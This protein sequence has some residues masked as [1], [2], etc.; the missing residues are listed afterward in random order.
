MEE[1]V[2]VIPLGHE[3]DRAVKPFEKYK[4]NRVHI[5]SV[6][7][8]F[9]KYSL[10]MVEEQK[11]FTNTVADRLR[12]LGIGITIH[13]LDMFNVLEVIKKISNIIYKEKTDGNIVYVNISSAGRLTSV[14]A[15]LSAMVHNAKAYYVVA[16]RY[17]AN[18]QEKKMH[19]ISIC[20][21]C[22]TNV[23]EPF[24]L[25]LPKENEMK[26]LVRLCK[27]GKGMKTADIIE[28]L[29]SK[30]IRG[31]EKCV[32]MRSRKV[33]RKDKINCLMKLNKG[34]LEKLEENGYI[35][36]VKIGKYNE[37]T[38]TDSG[39]YIAYISGLLE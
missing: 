8:T 9:K 24:K 31:F 23:L 19:G 32:D 39:K 10:E 3:I 14:A 16:D 21:R 20:E 11:Y 17:S 37:I 25:Q 18:K 5:L 35:K 29:A 28:F 1:I 38:I 2:H 13:T 36:R 4:A 7:E 33:P 30:H 6:L 27:E 15:Y 34:I 26:V 22:E 12:S